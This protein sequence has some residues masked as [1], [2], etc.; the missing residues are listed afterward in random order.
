MST[1]PRDLTGRGL[2][3]ALVAGAMRPMRV[4][5]PEID[6]QHLLQVTPADDQ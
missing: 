3:G 5:V 6:A 1:T 2:A 4:V